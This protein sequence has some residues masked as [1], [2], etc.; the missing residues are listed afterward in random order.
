MH[1]D[2]FRFD[3]P[4]RSPAPATRSTCAAH[5]LDRDRPGPGAAPREADRRA[6][7]RVDGRLPGRRVPAAV[8]GV[9]RPVTATTIRDFWRGRHSGGIRDVASRLAGSSDLYADDGRSPYASVNF[10]TAHDGFT[11]A[12]PG[13]LR[14]QA[15]RGQRRG[16]PRRHRQQPVVEPR[17][18]GRDRRPGDRRAA[19]PAG[20]QHDGHAVPVQRRP[21]DHRRRRARPHPA[22]QQ[23]RLLPGQRDLVGRLAARRRVARRLRDHQGRAPAAPRAP[24]AAAAALLRGPARR[25]RGGPK[26]LAWLH[27]DG[28][29]DDRATTGTTTRC[30]RSACSSPATRCAPPA[31]AASSSVDKS[32]LLWFNAGARAGRRHAARER[33][34]R[35]RRGRALHRPDAAV[36]T[37]VKA[38]DLGSR[39]RSRDVEPRSRE[40]CSA[41]L[42]RRPDQSAVR[43]RRRVLRPGS[44]AR[45]GV[46]QG[47]HAELG[48]RGQQV[49]ARD[50]PGPCSRTAPVR[51]SATSPSKRCRPPS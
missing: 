21:D 37:P 6:V 22:R 38:G 36:G 24:G 9:E 51:S 17:R 1:V 43:R 10:V 20:R 3:L 26:D 19:P 16:Q 39:L 41:E 45:S 46:G 14:A 30:T 32:F 31:R 5:L 27:P 18:R 4:R 11:R 40:P 47:D 50:A 15:Q 42:R 34:G 8:G 28:P 44:A 12:R 35:R 7:G 29:R 48:G 2:G 49:V 25:S 33:L 23:Q 13:H